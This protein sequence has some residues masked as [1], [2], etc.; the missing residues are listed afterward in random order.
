MEVA[1]VLKPMGHS[2][3]VAVSS[4]ITS[5]KTRAHPANI[6]GRPIPGSG[7]PKM[8]ADALTLD[9]LQPKDTY[10]VDRIPD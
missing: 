10:V 7:E 3:S 9:T 4:F 2:I 6:P 1:R 8:P 5:S